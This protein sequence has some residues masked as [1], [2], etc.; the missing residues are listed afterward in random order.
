MERRSNKGG[1]FLLCSMWDASLKRHCVVVLEGK[2][3]VGGKGIVGGKNLVA[4][5]GSKV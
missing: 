1:S 5:D 3:L 4:R 2:G